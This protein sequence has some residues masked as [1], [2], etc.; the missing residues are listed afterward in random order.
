MKEILLVTFYSIDFIS[1]SDHETH[2]ALRHLRRKNYSTF[3]SA[4][5]SIQS[6]FRVNHYPKDFKLGIKGRT[7]LLMP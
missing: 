5:Y 4:E 7:E 2:I 3:L 6:S 1:F